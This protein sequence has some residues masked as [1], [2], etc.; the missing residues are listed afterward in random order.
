VEALALPALSLPCARCARVSEFHCTERFRVNANGGRLDVWLLYR[1]AVCG[2]VHKQRLL[3]RVRPDAL[4]SSLL[5]GYQGDEPALVR[6]CAFE[7][8]GGA[9]VAYRVLRP[10]HLAAAPLLA[11]IVQPE[12][13]G[14]RWDRLLASELGCSRSRL[15]REAER[16][17]VRVNGGAE[18]QRTVADGDLLALSARAE[19]LPLAAARGNPRAPR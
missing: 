2:E 11:R 8:G 5:S 16:G 10:A 3:R 12:P 19:T 9:A 15:E 17:G 14:V 18:L 6:R 7:A 1:C 13:C 4:P